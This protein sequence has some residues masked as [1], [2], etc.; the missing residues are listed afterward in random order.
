MA[1]QGSIYNLSLGLDFHLGSGQNRGLGFD[2]LV[3]VISRKFILCNCVLHI[4]TNSRI[5][6]F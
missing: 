2:L 1:I 5:L 6:I 3:I 4:D